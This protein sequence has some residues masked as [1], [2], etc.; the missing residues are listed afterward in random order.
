M[1]CLDPQAWEVSTGTVVLELFQKSITR[2]TWPVLQW[3]HDDAQ[4][5]HMVTNTVHVYSRA[6]G[7]KGTA[8][9]LVTVSHS[10]NHSC[11]LNCQS[12][13]QSVVL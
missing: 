6:D 4:L 5:F 10:A 9:D 2:D 12:V 3:G 8:Y 7:F 13:L 1:C 11:I